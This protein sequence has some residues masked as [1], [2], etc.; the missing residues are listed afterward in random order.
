MVF[1]GGI[2]DGRVSGRCRYPEAEVFQ[3]LPY[4][5]LVSDKADDLHPV[6]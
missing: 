5:L 1:K 3:Y 6:R 4:Y 2:C